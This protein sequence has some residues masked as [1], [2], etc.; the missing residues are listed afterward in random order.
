MN[1]VEQ[2]F[3]NF[4]A[5]LLRMEEENRQLRLAGENRDTH[6][7]TSKV[8]F[9]DGC[10]NQPKSSGTPLDHLPSLYNQH[11]QS[12]QLELQQ[13]QQQ[14]VSTALSQSQVMAHYPR[15]DIQPPTN[16]SASAYHAYV[17][18]LEQD[19]RERRR[20]EEENNFHEYKMQRDRHRFKLQMEELEY[21][22]RQNNE[23]Y[24]AYTKLN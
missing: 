20:R 1:R 12:I 5:R 8:K 14:T 4:D 24:A 15:N 16:R 13:S 10:E 7:S 23:V 9:S 11:H 18:S 6:S 2:A 19:R 17:D 22:R 3:N 21:A